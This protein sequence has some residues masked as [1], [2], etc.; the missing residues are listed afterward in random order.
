MKNDLVGLM[1]LLAAV[2]MPLFNIPLIVRIIKRRSSQDISVIWAA[3]VWICILMMAPA[4][5]R[6]DDIVLR[7]FN[8]SNLL[9]FSAVFFVTI[10][11]RAK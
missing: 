9:F 6:S 10:K 5:F 1:G 7:T 8:I 3:G 2:I 11:Y 4:G